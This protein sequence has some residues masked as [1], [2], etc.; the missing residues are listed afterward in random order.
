ML[1]SSTLIEIFGCIVRVPISTSL[2]LNAA[3]KN[4][5]AE[6]TVSIGRLAEPEHRFT[7]DE[8]CEI[9]I[10]GNQVSVNSI[11]ELGPLALEHYVIDHAIPNGLATLGKVM[12]HAAGVYKAGYGVMLAGPSGAGKSTGSAFLMQNGWLSLGDDALRVS[13]NDTQHVLYSGYPGIRLFPDVVESELMKNLDVF[14]QVAEY[15][16]KTRLDPKSIA[17]RSEASPLALVVFLAEGNKFQADE[18]GKVAVAGDLAKQLFL[19]PAKSA[20]AINRLE[21]TSQLGADIPGYSVAIPRNREGLAS[22]VNW[23]DEEVA[24]V[25]KG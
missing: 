1:T 14:S 4:A 12:I 13:K 23:L 21:I 3:P 24:T 8:A 7:L 15:S 11:V 20:E 9:F 5:I 25:G 19:P 10:K 18:V 17:F 22:L 16:S 2:P 6:L